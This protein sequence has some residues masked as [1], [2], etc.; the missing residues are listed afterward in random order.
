MRDSPAR[1]SARGCRISSSSQATAEQ[2]RFGVSELVDRVI[3]YI[4]LATIAV[5]AAFLLRAGSYY[6]LPLWD[7]PD[8]PWHRAL[9]PSGTVGHPFGWIGAGLMLLGVL[10]YS[11]RKRVRVMRGRGP[12]RTWLNLHIYLC[13]TGPFLV[14]LHT[15]DKLR[16]LGVYSFWS[17]VVVAASG[18]VGRW[19]YQQFPRT[20]RGEAMTLEELRAEREAAHER[21]AGAFGLSPALL[22][23]IEDVSQ[24]HARRIRSSAGFGLLAVPLLFAD[25]VARPVQLARLRRRLRRERRLPR[26]EADA[27]LALIRR[28]AGAARRLAFFDTFRRLFTYWH[29]IHLVFFAAMLVLLVLHVGTELFFGAGLS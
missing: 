13:L 18:I 21:L 19:I 26:R 27:V 24:R 14:A 6:L 22:A 15:A 28:E 5:G 2:R 17:M 3:V 25:D 11:G 7:R 29:V 16:G 12:M 4:G 10:L 1:S 8:S 9:Q 23:Q 20:A